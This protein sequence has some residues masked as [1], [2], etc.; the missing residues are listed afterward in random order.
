MEGMRKEE[1]KK[2]RKTIIENDGRKE[3]GLLIVRQLSSPRAPPPSFCSLLTCASVSAVT[4]ARTARAAAATAARSSRSP[5]AA[6]SRAACRRCSSAAAA[7]ANS[8]TSRCVARSAAAA[9]SA[10]AR[11]SAAASSSWV[12]AKLP[13]S[14]RRSRAGGAGCTSQGKGEG[15][16]ITRHGVSQDDEEKKEQGRKK[17]EG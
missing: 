13:S 1:R 3:G 14:H 17:R 5:S 12:A 11:A 4:S 6:P 9:A 16:S 10:S 15:G 7:A 8:A 2:G